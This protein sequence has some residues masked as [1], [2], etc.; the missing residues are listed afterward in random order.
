LIALPFHNGLPDVGTGRGV[1]ALVD[2]LGRPADLV[3]PVD[4][5]LPEVRRT[6]E[7]DRAPRS[8]SRPMTR[9]PTH[10]RARAAAGALLE[11]V[12]RRAWAG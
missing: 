3:A 1:R 10:G 12:V 8:R 9:P 6:I 4:A 5:S 7:L 2:D 11:R